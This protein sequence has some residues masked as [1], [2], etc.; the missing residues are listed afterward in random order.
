M[1]IWLNIIFMRSES[2]SKK[3]EIRQN[4][5]VFILN[6]EEKKAGVVTMMQLVILSFHDQSIMKLKNKD[7]IDHDMIAPI[8]LISLKFRFC[9]LPNMVKFV[10]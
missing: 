3:E 6:Q 8:T 7:H 1:T 2:S 10:F 4:Q 5:L 9:L